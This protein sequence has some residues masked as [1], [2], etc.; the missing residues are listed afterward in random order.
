MW[1]KNVPSEV[2]IA[3]RLP[4]DVNYRIRLW[5]RYKI[6]SLNYNIFKLSAGAAL[7]G[8]ELQF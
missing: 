3:Y 7:G 4:F 8:L 1:R 5:Y 6:I 2:E